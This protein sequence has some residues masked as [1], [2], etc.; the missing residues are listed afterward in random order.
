M[1]TL[2]SYIG[3]EPFTVLVDDSK[4]LNELASQ[5]KKLKNLPFPEKM[6]KV[7]NLALDAIE[8][9][10]YEQW[11]V[12]Q[13]K[14]NE[15]TGTERENSLNKSGYFF[16]IVSNQH[17]LGYALEKKAGCCRYQGALFFVLGYE[18]GLGEKHFIQTA[19][20][21]QMYSVFNEVFENGKKHTV[22]IFKESLKDKSLDYSVQNPKI[23]EQATDIPGFN[24]YSYH[25][26][27]SGIVLVENLGKHI[28]EL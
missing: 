14:A 1:K 4:E 23:F 17:P 26:K 9:N 27:E 2:D 18:A 7:K 5:A 21:G 6:N 24:F 12:W 16:D 22:S 25:K 19:P 3:I 13:K 11:T 10:A 15:S 8:I 20:V 28:K